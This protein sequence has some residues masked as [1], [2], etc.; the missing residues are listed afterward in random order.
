MGTMVSAV[1]PLLQ[2]GASVGSALSPFINASQRVE[3]SDLGLEQARQKAVLERQ[4]NLLDLQDA[5]TE[6]Q[7]RLKRLV[8]AQRAKFGGSGVRSGGGS[9]EAVLQGLFGDS[10]IQRQQ[11]ESDFQMGNRAIDLGV[12]Q[13]QQLNLLQREQERQKALLSTLY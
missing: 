12:Y 11:N 2:V 13:E 8:S 7:A 1:A 4:K 6:R 5:E 3:K 9:S 10:D